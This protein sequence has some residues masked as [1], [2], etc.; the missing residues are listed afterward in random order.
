MAQYLSVLAQNLGFSVTVVSPDIDPD[1]VADD[2]KFSRE[3]TDLDGDFIVIATQGRHDRAALNAA[4]ESSA[5]YIAMIAS[6]KKFAGLTDRLAN[7]G[8]S[9]RDLQRI[10]NPAGIDIG[11]VTPQE[12]ALSILADLV[13]E[14][15]I[16]KSV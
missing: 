2:V 5:N 1:S 6:K 9:S 4:I 3:F 10:R 15:R 14:R 8:V 12:I 7:A 11:A 13:R 16:G